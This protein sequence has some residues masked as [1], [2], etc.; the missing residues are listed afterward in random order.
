MTELNYMAIDKTGKFV[1]VASPKMPQ[2]DLAKELAKWIRWGCS[3]ER[4]DDDFVRQK[5]GKVI[6]EPLL[7]KIVIY[8]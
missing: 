1:A 4:C 5:F 3:V 6:R 2:Q 7:K 8:D